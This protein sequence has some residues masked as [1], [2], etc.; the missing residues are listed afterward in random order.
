MKAGLSAELGCITPWIFVPTTSTRI[1]FDNKSK[2]EDWTEKSVRHFA[3]YLVNCF[4]VNASANCLSPKVVILSSDWQYKQIFLESLRKAMSEMTAAAPYYPNWEKRF[5]RF[6]A[7]YGEDELELI[8]APTFSPG[9][10]YTKRALIKLKVRL[11]ITY[12]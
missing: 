3:G 2:L 9:Q 7:A 6:V 1:N 8:D 10:T 12:L 5:D 11:K 4:N